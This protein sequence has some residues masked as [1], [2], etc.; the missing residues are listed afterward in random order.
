MKLLSAQETHCGEESLTLCV[1][2]RFASQAERLSV[3]P[4][5]DDIAAL[6]PPLDARWRPQKRAPTQFVFAHADIMQMKFRSRKRVS[7]RTRD[8]VT[9]TLY[10][11]TVMCDQRIRPCS[12][13]S[14]VG[15]RVAGEETFDVPSRLRF[16]PFSYLSSYRYV[17]KMD[18]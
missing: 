15:Q 13:G 9:G 17:T 5:Q 2:S 3:P 12:T 11:F 1:V 10:W 8:T 6:E 7:L 16:H 18:V 14:L 4:P